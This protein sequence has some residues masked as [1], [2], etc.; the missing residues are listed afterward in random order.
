VRASAALGERQQQLAQHEL[1]LADVYALAKVD[2]IGERSQLDH[3]LERCA[4]HF[5]SL[6]D[7]ITTHYLIHAGPA[8]QIGEIR[9]S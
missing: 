3:F 9:P 1:R 4:A 5:R 6:S 8:R 7:E 2:A